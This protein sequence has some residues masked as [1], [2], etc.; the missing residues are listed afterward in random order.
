[1]VKV[2]TGVTELQLL[3]NLING[4]IE[5]VVKVHVPIKVDTRYAVEG[6]AGPGL[7][8]V[9]G[10]NFPMSVGADFGVVKI[11]NRAIRVNNLAIAAR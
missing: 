6:A 4:P 9:T 7:V 5:I 3:A 1:V 11:G 2:S 8:L 10:A